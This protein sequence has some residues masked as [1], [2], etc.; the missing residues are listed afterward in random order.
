MEGTAEGSEELAPRAGDEQVVELGQ[1][2]TIGLG[3]DEGGRYEMAQDVGAPDPD[4]GE[5]G[6][7]EE[8]LELL[9]VEATRERVGAAPAAGRVD[10]GRARLPVLA[11]DGLGEDDGQPAGDEQREDATLPQGLGDGVE[12]GCGV[13]DELQRAEAAGEVDATAGEDGA[14]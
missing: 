3:V 4:V 1:G 7:G 12:R 2:D 14:Q 9:D 6:V 5:A 13:V 11:G 10:E 8:G